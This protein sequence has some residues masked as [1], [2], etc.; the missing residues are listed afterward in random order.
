MKK[1]MIALATAAAFSVPFMGQASAATYHVQPGDSLW[2]IANENNVTVNDLKEWNG[3]TSD[4][5]YPNQELVVN[6]E[7]KYKI[8]QGDTLSGIAKQFGVTVSSIK[9]ANHL[10]SDL[11][12]AGDVLVIEKAGKAAVSAGQNKT[13]V[14]AEKINQASQSSSPV[15]KEAADRPEVNQ[16]A[17]D[18]QAAAS[19]NTVSKPENGNAV[20][21]SEAATA[22]NN[23]VPAEKAV[24]PK[25]ISQPEDKG[26]PE[27]SRQSLTMEATAYSLVGN[28]TATGTK[29]TKD[30][31][32]VAV[33][34][35]VIPLGSKVYIEGFGTYTAADTGG[36]IKGNKI[37]IHMPTK[38]DAVNFGRRQV[39]VTKLNHE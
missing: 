12:F 26:A 8:K 23:A 17:K 33:D 6:E 7:V 9:S 5:I 13:E 31:K 36:A 32:V 10:T 18:L 21:E 11:I 39:Q 29:L 1:S 34:P 4:N 15:K 19:N 22:K 25:E 28:T 38:Q 3:L 2:K 16:Q 27:D 14:R 20:A 37:D 35:S 30:S 24:A